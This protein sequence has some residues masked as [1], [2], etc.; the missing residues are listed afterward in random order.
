MVCSEPSPVARELRQHTALEHVRSK[1]SLVE[2][3]V[4]ILSKDPLDGAVSGTNDSRGAAERRPNRKGRRCSPHGDAVED[5]RRDVKEA[6]LNSGCPGPDRDERLVATVGI[7]VKAAEMSGRVEV[8]GVA[9][10]RIAAAAI[11]EGD[12][13]PPRVGSRLVGDRRVRLPVTVVVP[14]PS[15][16]PE[17]PVR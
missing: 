1:A 7:D 16:K 15:R 14:C 8:L 5:T 3:V 13:N 10:R 4:Q 2:V 6:D 11:S 9:N 17:G 12:S